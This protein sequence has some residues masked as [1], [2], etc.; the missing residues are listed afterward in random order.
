MIEIINKYGIYGKYIFLICTIICVIFFLKK[1]S[2]MPIN[3]FKPLSIIIILG[4]LLFVGVG[5]AVI[6]I[7]TSNNASMSW[8]V[9]RKSYNPKCKF[10]GVITAIIDVIKSGCL[11]HKAFVS[12]GIGWDFSWMAPDYK[13]SISYY[14]EHIIF[15]KFYRVFKKLNISSEGLYTKWPS[16]ANPAFFIALRLFYRSAS[17]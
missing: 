17:I 16:P 14:I 6:T 1:K 8:F 9:D 10:I 15:L 11:I 5:I 12:I 7:V 13:C 3:K 4:I 2:I